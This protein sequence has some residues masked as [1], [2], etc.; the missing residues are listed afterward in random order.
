MSMDRRLDRRTF[1]KLSSLVALTGIGGLAAGC[2]PADKI[3]RS[4]IVGPTA[5]GEGNTRRIGEVEMTQQGPEVQIVTRNAV[6]ARK[7]EAVVA[8]EC[9]ATNRTPVDSNSLI[10]R[11]KVPI[12][13]CINST[14][15]KKRINALLN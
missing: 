6:I 10:R 3:A 5:P 1:L 14:A 13:N 8:E 7:A 4:A 12:E 9:D 2:L 11:L 15:V